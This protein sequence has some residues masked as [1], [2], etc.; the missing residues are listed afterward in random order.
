MKIIIKTTIIC[1][2]KNINRELVLEAESMGQIGMMVKLLREN[3]VDLERLSASD[4]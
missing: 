4:E 3:N 1:G 2:N